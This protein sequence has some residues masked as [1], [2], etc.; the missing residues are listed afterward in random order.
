MN[1]IL[2]YSFS[3]SKNEITFV[4]FISDTYISVI[5]LN[6]FYKCYKIVKKRIFVYILFTVTVIAYKQFK[7]L[8]VVLNASF[9]IAIKLACFDK[10]H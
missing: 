9:S 3:D 8:S 7:M 1:N 4:I 6:E 10:L 2:L 5:I